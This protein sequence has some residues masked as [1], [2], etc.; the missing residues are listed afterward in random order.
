VIECDPCTFRSILDEL[1]NI[2]GCDMVRHSNAGEKV[3][4]DLGTRGWCQPQ[5]S[6]GAQVEARSCFPGEL[7]GGDHPGS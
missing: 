3:C 7:C 4:A 2:E 5:D 1:V 6:A